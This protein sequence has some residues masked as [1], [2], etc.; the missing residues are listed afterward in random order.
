MRKTLFYTS[1]LLTCCLSNAYAQR[2]RTDSNSAPKNFWGTFGFGGSSVGPLGMLTA[3]A[4]IGHHYVFS[5]V[6][7]TEVN[8][9]WSTETN[10]LEVTRYNVLFGKIFRQ[11]YTFLTVSAGVGTVN[12]TTYDRL[13][14][15]T[16]KNTSDRYAFEVPVMVQYYL[17]MTKNV[18]FGIQ[19]FVDFNRIR[20][21]EGFSIN[22][23]FGRMRTRSGKI[24]QPPNL[25]GLRL[26]QP[27][28]HGSF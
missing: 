1:V 17:L 28:H 14:D 25:P 22:F 20:T 8:H 15:N 19:G 16:F 7:E 12:F 13:N 9:F 21:T 11:Q 2:A 10:N 23:A 24:A 3:S 4:E 26:P 5:A 27:P 6:A 18:S